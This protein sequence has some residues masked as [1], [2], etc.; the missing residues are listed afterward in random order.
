LRPTF[1]DADVL[2]AAA[3]GTEELSAPAL[4]VLYDPGRSF[5]CSDYLKLEVLPIAT[6][7]DRMEV[8]AFYE[9]FFGAVSHWVSSSP[10]LS[11]RALD[12]ACRYG[13]GAVDA[14][15]VAA[16]E[17]VGA[18]LVTAERPT[19]PM[20]RVGTSRVTSIRNS[21]DARRRGE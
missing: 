20:L 4:A 18:E 19:K 10:E 1:I 6:F 11:E 14:L 21:I 12:L 15:H 7:F 9:E 8:V 16:A 17:V 3:K 5:V 2:I 13:L